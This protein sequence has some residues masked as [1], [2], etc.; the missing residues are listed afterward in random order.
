MS[1]VYVDRMEERELQFH[2][3]QGIL[4]TMPIIGVFSVKE[5]Y[6]MVL[7]SEPPNDKTPGELIIVRVETQDGKDIVQL[8]TDK[9]EWDIA[10]KTW[11]LIIDE[12]ER[13]GLV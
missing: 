1:Q 3:E 7:H 12:V 10:K 5:K 2:D 13:Q 4:R 6:Y 8:I 9:D 11:E